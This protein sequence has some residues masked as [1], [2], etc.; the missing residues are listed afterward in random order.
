[1]I[2]RSSCSSPND[3]YRSIIITS[4]CLKGNKEIPTNITMSVDGERF[5]DVGAERTVTC[6]TV[7]AAEQVGESSP[8]ADIDL[9]EQLIDSNKCT[10]ANVLLRSKENKDENEQG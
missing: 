10:F 6:S 5:D 4:N 8:A 9:C 7:L 2:S 3:N 1:M